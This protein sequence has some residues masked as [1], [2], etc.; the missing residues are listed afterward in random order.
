MF[1]LLYYLQ[2]YCT[3]WIHH[4]SACLPITNPEFKKEVFIKKLYSIILVKYDGF[5]FGENFR[6][7]T[8]K[9]QVDPHEVLHA[10][11]IGWGIPKLRW[12]PFLPRVY[13]YL[14][15]KPRFSFL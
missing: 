11:F 15:K 14:G 2:K 1:L 5:N 7:I 4:F 10:K 3:C 12:F 6:T 9:L 8:G 13:G